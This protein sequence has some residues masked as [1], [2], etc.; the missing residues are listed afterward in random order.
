MSLTFSQCDV[1]VPTTGRRQ[2]QIH[3]EIQLAADSGK[4]LKIELSERLIASLRST[5]LRYWKLRGRK[6]R[7]R[8]E[9]D[10]LIVWLDPLPKPKETAVAAEVKA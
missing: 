8:V 6:L 9:G 4:A 1:P 5:L 2:W 7:T 3:R 10:G